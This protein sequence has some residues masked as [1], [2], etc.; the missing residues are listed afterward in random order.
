MLVAALCLLVASQEKQW[1]RVA[2]LPDYD[3]KDLPPGFGSFDGKMHVQETEGDPTKEL[4]DIFSKLNPT[5]NQQM[6]KDQY[7]DLL[8]DL[9][10]GAGRGDVEKQGKDSIAAIQH[11]LLGS[12][13]DE[14]VDL[15]NKETNNMQDLLQDLDQEKL[16]S[17]IDQNYKRKLDSMEL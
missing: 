4:E 9:I 16:L 11:K 13:I 3:D 17:Y 15:D 7:K 6:T 1:K 12:I 8:K 10:L 5:G 14:Y 2:D